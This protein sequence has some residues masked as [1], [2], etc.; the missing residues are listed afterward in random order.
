MKSDHGFTL[1][2]ALIALAFVSV[3]T[4]GLASLVIASTGLVRDAHDDTSA[5]TLAIQK[6][7]EL[8]QSINA[9]MVVPLS[10]DTS[11][12]TDV[13]GFSDHTDT[14]VRR[15]RVSL[16]PSGEASMRIVQVRVVT[17]RLSGT[18]AAGS[19]PARRPGEVML[20]AI[21]APR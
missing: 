20:I 11:L 4:T 3:M 18:S 8:R 19:A 2:E 6:I 17:A 7:E 10:P 1:I 5:S 12:E 14:Y 9:G 16:L 13:S 21:A 15:W